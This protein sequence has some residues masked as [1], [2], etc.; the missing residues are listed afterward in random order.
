MDQS[1]ER[2]YSTADT[3]DTVWPV[4]VLAHNEENNIAACLDSIYAAE[5]GCSFRVFV[6]ANGCT[7]NTEQIVNE[8]G[9]THE[10]VQVVS[11]AVGDRCNAWNVFIHET[12]PKYVPGSN[13]YFFMD[14]DCRVAPGSFSEL[15]KALAQNPEANAAG[16]PPLSGREK[17]RDAKDLLE[18]R[19]LV[20]NLYALSGRFVRDIQAKSVRLPLGL[21]AADDG[22]IGALAKWNLDPL[23][24][25][26]DKYV[27]PCPKAGFLFDSLS[28]TSLKQWRQ[29]WRRLVLYGRRHYDNQLLAKKLKKEGI[30][31]MP[32]RIS[33]LY[34]DSAMLKLHWQGIYTLPNLVAL[35][36]IRKKARELKASA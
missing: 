26:N 13:V 33:D 32:K 31:G 29:Y 6:M 21:D 11:I 10:G 5:A 20:A 22:L 16:A 12:A 15:A 2:A 34:T 27:V 4:M 24:Q 14:G 3:K 7:D 28:L 25:F 18:S 35:R 23:G 30:S 36:R 19:G 1:A 8:Y 9:K 17:E